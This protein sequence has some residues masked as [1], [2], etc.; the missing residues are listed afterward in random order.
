MMMFESIGIA[1]KGRLIVPLYN[2]NIDADTIVKNARLVLNI[3]TIISNK[4]ERVKQITNLQSEMVANINSDGIWTSI[5][6]INIRYVISEGNWN[7]EK[8][9][10]A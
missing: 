6:C 3:A 1:E 8:P 10:S 2:K 5:E 4:V 9:N 7:F